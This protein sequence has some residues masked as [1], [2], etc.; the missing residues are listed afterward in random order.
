MIWF[1]GLYQKPI[2]SDYEEVAP[3]CGFFVVRNF[4]FFDFKVRQVI[5]GGEYEATSKN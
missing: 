2:I 5:E 4:L 3:A 1:G